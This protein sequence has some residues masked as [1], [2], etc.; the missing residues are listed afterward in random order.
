MNR[1][2]VSTVVRIPPS[3]AYEFLLD[4]PGYAAYSNHLTGVDQSGDGGPGTRYRL[5]F[6]WWKLTY[7]VQSEVTE[8]E[9]PHRIEWEVTKDLDASGRWRVEPVET[10]DGAGS[11][12]TLEVEYDPTSADNAVSLPAFV[13]LDWVVEKAAARVVEEGER[14]VERIVADLE[15]ERRDVDLN[16]ATE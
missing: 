16:V 14:V 6:S 11:R 8:V 3:E 7:T 15:G 5:H 2:S 9:P 4:F 1:L 12:V 13:S 10:E